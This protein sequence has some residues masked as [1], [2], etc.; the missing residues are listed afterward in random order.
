[1]VKSRFAPANTNV[2][3]L[4][5]ISP[6]NPDN[7]AP[8]FIV[9]FEVFPVVIVPVPERVPF[10]IIVGGSVGLFPR[11]KEQSLL[12]VIVPAVF[13][14]T[15]LLKVALLQPTVLLLLSRK[16]TVPPLALNVPPV[17][18]KPPTIDKFPLGAVNVPEVKVNT[19]PINAGL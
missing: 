14:I 6:L 16:V 8:V 19:P 3:A 12:I 7:A 2:L 1:M 17:I 5:T 4:G 9:K 15:T 13:A 10:N 18:P 11:G